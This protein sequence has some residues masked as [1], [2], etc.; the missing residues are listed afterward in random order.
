MNIEIMELESICKNS[1]LQEKVE[2]IINEYTQNKNNLKSSYISCQML[3]EFVNAKLLTQHLKIKLP[4]YD[5]IN[6]IESYI[7][8]DQF[9]SSLMMRINANYNL[10]DMNHLT[11]T[12]LITI[13][14]DLDALYG[15]ILEKYGDVI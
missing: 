2:K 4:N 12:D 3:I 10:I 11:E 1:Y 15:H 14:F 5:I 8:I 6:I 9:L 13:L 7:P